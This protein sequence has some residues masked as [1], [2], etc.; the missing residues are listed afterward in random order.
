MPTSSFIL[1][2]FFAA[3]G[4]CERPTS[5]VTG[6]TFAP[7]PGPDPEPTELVMDLVAESS[8][9]LD[10]GFGSSVAAS[11]DTV[12]VGA[13]H[14]VVGRVFRQ[15]NMGVELLVEGEGRLGSHLAHTAAGLWVGA[16]LGGSGAGLVVDQDGEPIASGFLGTGIVVSS[17]GGGTY[18]HASGIVTSDGRT[19]TTADRPGSVAEADGT[20]GVGMPRGPIV[21]T[22]AGSELRRATIGD[23]AGFALAAVDWDADGIEDWVVGAPGSGTVTVYGHDQLRPLH[24]WSAPG[25]FGAAIAVCDLDRNGTKDLL[26]GAPFDGQ[27][28][29]VSWYPNLADSATPLAVEWPAAARAVGTA[30][31]C[32]GDRVYVG[33]P[34]DA[35]HRGMLLTITVTAA[36]E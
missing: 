23:E 8:P 35:V 33:A 29:S 11:A 17:V 25:R 15:T 9:Y 30:I 32:E 6:L 20:L 12:W 22:A 26:I 10:D 2:V 19:V 16:P 13:P 4:G 21:L 27:T 7:E 1:A 31:A 5:E 3:L 28:G 18:G 36:A 34:G 14:G 24:A